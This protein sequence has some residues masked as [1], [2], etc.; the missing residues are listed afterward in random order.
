MPETP[1]PRIG[2]AVRR[3][4]ALLEARRFHA[5]HEAFEEGWR[6]ASGEVRTLLQALVQLAA[7][8]HHLDRGRPGP[9]RKLLGRSRLRLQAPEPA[10]GGLRA[11]R[12]LEGLDRLEA[13]IGRGNAGTFPVPPVEGSAGSR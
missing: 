10:T 9:A 1:G 2:E 13:W 8:C 3:G 7:A 11:D 6:L 5:A 4:A 12:L